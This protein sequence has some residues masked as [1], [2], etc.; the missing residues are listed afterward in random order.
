M[1]PKSR[2]YSH[3]RKVIYVLSLCRLYHITNDAH[4]QAVDFV[5]YLGK[6]KTKKQK[7]Q[8]QKQKR[9]T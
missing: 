6:D 5:T 9:A 1:C 4:Q 3:L 2:P 8:K 7:K